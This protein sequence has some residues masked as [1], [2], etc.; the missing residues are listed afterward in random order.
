MMSYK[1]KQ[2][3]VFHPT[4]D[5]VKVTKVG[6]TLR[7]SVKS[8]VLVALA[9]KNINQQSKTRIRYLCQK[10]SAWFGS[11]QYIYALHFNVAILAPLVSKKLSNS[12]YILWC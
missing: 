12:E 5:F 2:I 10:Q 9:E 3:F 1:K 7:H 11:I 6:E 8:D 4:I